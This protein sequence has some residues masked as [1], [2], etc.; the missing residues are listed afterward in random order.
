MTCRYFLTLI[1]ILA[2]PIGAA[3]VDGRMVD[4]AHWSSARRLLDTHARFGGSR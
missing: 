4:R 3:Q 2:L 1:F